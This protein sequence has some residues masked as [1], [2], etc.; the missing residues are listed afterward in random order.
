MEFKRDELR[1]Y[2]RYK[3]IIEGFRVNYGLTQLSFKELDK[4]LWSYGKEIFGNEL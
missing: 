2:S 4:F 1:Q 3:E